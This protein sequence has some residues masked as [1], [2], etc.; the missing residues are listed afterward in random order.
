MNDQ[1]LKQALLNLPDHENEAFVDNVFVPDFLDALGFDLMERIP[2]YSTGTGKL[3][4][5][6]A[7]RHNTKDDIFAQ[8]KSNPFILVELKGRD[9][10][11]TEGSSRYKA[12]V[13]Q[14]RRYLLSPNC[15]TVQWGIITN[16]KHIQLFRKHGKVIYPATQCLEINLDN[17]GEV[18]QKVAKIIQDTPRALT[19]AVYNNKGG[20]GKTTTTVNLASVLAIKGKKVLVVDF[21]PN[22]Q[23]LTNSL[24]IKPGKVTFYS[25][26]KDRKSNILFEDVMRPYKINYQRLK[27][28]FI[29]DVIPADEK[30]F[31][32]G[33]DELRQELKPT[34]LRQFIVSLKSNYDYILIDAPPNWRFFSVSA[35]QAADVVFMPTKHNNIFSL[36]NAAIAISKYI[37]EVQKKRKDG[38]PIA[39]PIFFNGEKITD[40]ARNTANKA[41]QNIIKKTKKECKFDLLPYFYPRYTSAQKNTHIF[42][43]P[44]Y[45]H[46]ADAAFSRIPAAYKNKTARDYYL[47]LAKEYFLQ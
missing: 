38:G 7:L 3:A 31:D 36:E 40:A 27:K 23:D 17:V 13:K 44:S 19:V 20:V 5:D 22:Q 21:D 9:I 41:I 35:V 12:T 28:E 39:L 30:L 25:C 4:V 45:A 10:D 42:D 2:E 43:V 11:L 47:S 34:R 26:L 33:E 6:Y 14:I 46:I 32:K 24:G 1:A 37:P 16:S 8:T 29:F 15:K 18:I